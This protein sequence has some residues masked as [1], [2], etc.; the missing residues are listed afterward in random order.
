MDIFLHFLKSLFS[1][2]KSEKENIYEADGGLCNC[3]AIDGKV[4]FNNEYF[5]EHAPLKNGG[6]T[7]FYISKCK[8]CGGVAGFPS[9]NFLNYL[10]NG[11]D[12]CVEQLRTEFNITKEFSNDSR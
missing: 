6:H 4:S 8:K 7:M 12:E 11:T 10:Q 3:M 5:I 9:D 1:N 2:D